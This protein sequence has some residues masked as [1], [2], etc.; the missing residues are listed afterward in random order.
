[1]RLRSELG[2]ALGM[3]AA[4]VTTCGPPRAALVTVE[5]TGFGRR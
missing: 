4:R 1:M 5:P 2:A 3:L